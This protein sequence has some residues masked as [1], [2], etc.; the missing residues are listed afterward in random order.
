MKKIYSLLSVFL[1]GLL[2]LT[3]CGNGTEFTLK[4]TLGTE[5]G[6]EFLVVYDDPLA[7]I[8][9]IL[10]LEG[11]FEYNFTPDTIT[12]I[13][14]VNKQGQVIP[15]FA[16]KGWTVN[17]KGTFDAPNLE[18]NAHN[19]DYAD[20]LSSVRKFDNNKDTIAV[21][22]EAFIR[23]H[24]NS[25]ASAYLIDQYFIQAPNPDVEKIKGLIAPLSGEV[26]DS[27]ILNVA[28][29]SIPIEKN[30]EGKSMGYFSIKDRNEKY[31]SWSMKRN[32]CILVN[33]WASWEPKSIAACDS[34]QA[35]I[36]KL[37]KNR[38]KVFNISLDYN[39]EQWLRNCR[40]DSENW[41]EIC[42][43]QGWETSIAKQNNILCL[44][45]NILINHQREI[46]ARD[47]F[48]NS[49]VKTLERQIE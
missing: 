8:D 37:P 45:S 19:H 16:D 47:I 5:K 22:A 3:A 14:L 23:S 17:C 41:F 48:G 6:E 38:L 26:K 12:L 34:L 46:I 29:K 42:S 11:K 4:G 21:A 28:L 24:P 32:E 39:K 35:I 43:M 7:K 44:P 33:F 20:F 27:R 40:P 49:L 30:K 2:L 15:I 10:P 13:R 18:G 1:G 9:T 36:K 25:F 31:L